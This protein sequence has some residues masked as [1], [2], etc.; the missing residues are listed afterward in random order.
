MSIRAISHSV[1]ALVC[2]AVLIPLMLVLGCG[3]A[4]LLQPLLPE[5]AARKS[6]RYAAF[7]LLLLAWLWLDP[8]GWGRPGSWF[9]QLWVRGMLWGLALGLLLEGALLLL[10]LHVPRSSFSGPA[11]LQ[12]ILKGLATGC[13]VALLEESVFR[14][15]LLGG[16]RR[17]FGVAAAIVV[18]SLVFALLHFLD[19][20]F[21]DTGEPFWERGLA[22]IPA[23]MALFEHPGPWLDAGLALFLLGALLAVMRVQDGSLGCC[24]GVHMAVVALLRPTRYLTEARPDEWAVLVSEQRPPLGLLAAAIFA[25]ALVWRLTR[26]N[27]PGVVI[28]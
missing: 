1:A 9:V 13:G 25:A 24:I 7:G 23:V 18:S 20:R 26:F 6:A 27:R 28:R 17:H 19:Y 15:A 11:L 3:L 2:C 4:E 21:L 5:V 22:V 8:G 14:G 10:G 12:E 16:L